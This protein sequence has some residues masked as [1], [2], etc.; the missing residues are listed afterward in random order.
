MTFQGTWRRGKALG[1]ISIGVVL[2]AVLMTVGVLVGSSND[3]ADAF[4]SVDASVLSQKPVHEMITRVLACT[5]N[6]APVDCFEPGS[7]AVLAGGA[8]SF[9]AVGEPD[10]PLDGFPNPAARHCDEGDYGDGTNHTQAEAWVELTKCIALYQQYLNFSVASAA[11]LLDQNG[12]INAS[13]TTITNVFGGSTNACSFPDPA[14]GNT[15]SDTAKCNVLNGLGRALHIHEDVW[16]HSNW[17]DVADPTT[18]IATKVGSVVSNPP[19]L[20][21][22]DDPDFFRYPGPIAT[23]FPEGFISGCDDSVTAWSCGNR[24]SHSQVSKD[25]GTVDPVTCIGSDPMTPRGKVVVDGVS[26]FQR[27]VTGACRAALR[28]WNDLKAALVATYG[29]DAAGKMAQAI[30][31]DTPTTRCRVSG[32]AAQA[33]APPTGTNKSARA[34]TITFVNSS[35]SPLLCGD[36]TLDGGQ[37]ANYPPDQIAPRTQGEWRTQSAGLATGTSGSVTF[38][39][40]STTNSVTVKWSNPFLGSNVSS[41]TATGGW[42]CVTSGGTGNDASLTVTVSDR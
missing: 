7:I 31:N 8:G 32:A 28:T 37:W 41:C 36:A 29:A 42:R 14:K 26:N 23:T 18:P 27:A 9:G 35:N 16:S 11:G 17:G 30:A 33:I 22:T 25:N 12:S 4:G 24:Y 3:R 34:V 19:G 2:M 38:T 40:G 15:S 1:S 13:A 39:D 20:G 21:R 5:S 6:Q 10:N